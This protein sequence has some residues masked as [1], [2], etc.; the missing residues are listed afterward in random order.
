MGNPG[1]P[2]DV[3]VEELMLM[4]SAGLTPLEVLRAA[5]SKAGAEL[6]RPRLGRLAQGS[7]ADLWAVP[8]DAATDLRRLSHP[9]LA[10]VRGTL[11]RQP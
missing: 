8:G 11:V 4:E 7:S 6:R 3:D 1:I 10:I 9:V 2:E 5:T